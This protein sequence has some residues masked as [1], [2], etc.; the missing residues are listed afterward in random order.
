MLTDSQMSSF[1]D[2]GVFMHRGVWSKI[3]QV[4]AIVIVLGVS[5]CAEDPKEREKKN[6]STSSNQPPNVTPTASTGDATSTT[7]TASS[8]GDATPTTTPV[9]PDP[10]TDKPLPSPQTFPNQPL[11]LPARGD[12]HGLKNLAIL[13]NEV[14]P[15]TTWQFE[16]PA[17]LRI[18][19]NGGYVDVLLKT[20]SF[21]GTPKPKGD[22]SDA[23][24][25][26]VLTLT[27][28]QT[29]SGIAFSHHGGRAFGI[30]S[31]SEGSLSIG[32]TAAG[33]A[34]ITFNAGGTPPRVYIFK[35]IK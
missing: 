5:G 13:I 15:A 19:K 9:N 31:A 16:T 8:T 6:S 14:F 30:S 11:N 29:A 21:T 20:V 7:T 2:G 23:E 26:A 3:R 24:I 1:T 10:S 33:T 17:L 18:Y 34:E 4:F 32:V 28:G 35:R 25:A 27:N 22:G 12:G